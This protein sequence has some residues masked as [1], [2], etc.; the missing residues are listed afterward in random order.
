MSSESPKFTSQITMAPRI[1]AQ[2]K[3][4]TSKWSPKIAPTSQSMNALMKSSSNP[5]VR[6]TTGRV[7]RI[8]SG[9]MKRFTSP[10]TSA[11]ESSH[12]NPS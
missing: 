5:S 1:A 12:Q 7:S 4:A 2:K 6:I 9:R 10:N 8:R 11:G 3:S